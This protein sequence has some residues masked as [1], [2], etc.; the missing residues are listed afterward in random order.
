MCD[1]SW[2]ELRSFHIPSSIH[3]SIPY[4]LSNQ[5]AVFLI[6]EKEILSSEGK[7]FHI[8]IPRAFQASRVASVIMSV[9]VS[10]YLSNVW[11]DGLFGKLSENWCKTGEKRPSLILGIF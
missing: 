10:H 11:K 8:D 6:S 3:P 9:P 7:T 2:G 4:E 1:R 5:L